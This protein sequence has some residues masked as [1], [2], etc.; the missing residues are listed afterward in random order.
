VKPGRVKDHHAVGSCG[1]QPRETE[2][3]ERAGH[4]LPDRPDRIRQLLL[5]HSCHQTACERCCADARSSRWAA[6]RCFTDPKALIAVCC[7]VSYSRRFSSSAISTTRYVDR[8]A[9]D[10][11]GFDPDEDLLAQVLALNLSVAD[12]EQAGGAVRGPGPQGLANT[13]RTTWRIESV[14]RLI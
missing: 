3:A 5:G 12:L 9:L 10:A 14:H 8:A 1:H 6:T 7:R 4:D 11:Y 2:V 13:T